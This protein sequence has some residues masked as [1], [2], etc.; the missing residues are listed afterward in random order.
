[1]AKRKT[2][3]TK[4]QSIPYM[5]PFQKNIMISINIPIRK[6][7]QPKRLEII[8]MSENLIPNYFTPLEFRI[9]VKRLPY[10]EFFTQQTNI[11]NISVSPIVQ[12][13]RFNPVY[14]I[15]DIV[16]YGNLDLN[17]IIDEQMNNYTEIF[18]WM[19]SAAFP[20]K[21]E[22]YQ[23]LEKTTD[24]RFS[25]IIITIMNSKKNSNIEITYVNCFPISLSDVQLNTTDSDV[26]YPQAVATFQYDS[27]SIKKLTS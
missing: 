13:T 22:Q 10:C 5:D 17:F 24:G 9:T 15:G 6:T 4:L 12:P 26:I 7:S 11:P 23:T 14:Q 1:M 8:Q 27:F 20:Q 19:I 21:H 2:D 18:D 16:T 3:K 25:D